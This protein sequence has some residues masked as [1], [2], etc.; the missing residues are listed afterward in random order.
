M[1]SF[2]SPL[3]NLFP[4]KFFLLIFFCHELNHKFSPV[5]SISSRYSQRVQLSFQLDLTGTSETSLTGPQTCSLKTGT[6]SQPRPG[7]CIAA[8][9]RLLHH[10]SGEF[11]LPTPGMVL[12]SRPQLSF[13]GATP[14]FADIASC[15]KVH[16]E[17]H[18]SGLLKFYLHICLRLCRSVEFQ[19]KNNYLL[20]SSVAIACNIFILDHFMNTSFSSSQ[21]FLCLCNLEGHFCCH[22]YSKL[23]QECTLV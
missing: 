13:P 14:H 21:C 19:D 3:N 17:V 7:S 15:E 5:V 18:F 4:R 6:T 12:F 1:M 20:I 9:F 11:F 22:Q 23:S 10:P 16:K 8:L 2:S